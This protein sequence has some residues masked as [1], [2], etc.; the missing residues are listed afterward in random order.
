MITCHLFTEVYKIYLGVTS[1]Q[2]FNGYMA[3]SILTGGG[4]LQMYPIFK[5]S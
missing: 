2:H 4:R 3:I 1:Y 5:F